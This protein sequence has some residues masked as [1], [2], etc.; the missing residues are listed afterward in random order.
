MRSIFVALLASAVGCSTSSAGNGDGGVDGGGCSSS[1]T[2]GA[3]LVVTAFG[4]VQG[5]S[6]NDTWA[7]R[8]IPFAA[9]PVGALR[10][11]PP[12]APSCWTA[13]LAA[14]AFGNACV[15]LDGSGVVVGN[16]DC[17]T[18]NVW[19]PSSA[20]PA[21]ALPVL[22]F[23]HGGGN[24]QGGS[25]EERNGV[26]LYDGSLL[27]AR[28][29]SI[30][31]TF[32]Y[33]LGPMGW[34][35]HSALAAESAMHVAGNY[36]TLDQIAALRF[37]AGSIAA[38]GGDPARVLLFGESAGAQDTC[39]LLTSPLAKGLFAA[40]LMESGGCVATPAA[41]A[42]SFADT[43]A[44]KAGC[45]AGDV[46][47]CLRALDAATVEQLIPES[48]DVAGAGVGDYQPSID[49]YVIPDNP[50]T[51]LAA[52]Q[53]NHVPFVVGSNANETGQVIVAQYPT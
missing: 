28:T 12:A 1:V 23:V 17:L 10:W 48:A 53:H 15:Q 32:N 20:T 40:A 35:A 31:V 8:G 5:T 25:G 41:A 46:A 3:G 4:P 30:V 33:R 27:A 24:T 11:Q 52:G 47:A 36:G 44:Q 18:L 13:P 45:T 42:S 21:S 2:P 34:L 51:R 29:N 50:Q 38:F 14:S 49:G 37:V 6:E 19:A 16:E 22:F 26:F 7:Y 43:L 9:P 39:T